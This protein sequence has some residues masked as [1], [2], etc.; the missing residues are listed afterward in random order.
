MFYSFCFAE[1]L[2]GE[3]HQVDAGCLIH[4]VK[5]KIGLL[6]LPPASSIYSGLSST[7]L[8]YYTARDFKAALPSGISQIVC[9][10]G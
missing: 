5:E 3:K 8:A 10:D 6:H 9:E 7:C 1:P 2:A 4:E